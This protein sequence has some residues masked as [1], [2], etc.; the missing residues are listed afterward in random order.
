MLSFKKCKREMFYNILIFNFFLQLRFICTRMRSLK[1][2]SHMNT[3][4]F[5]D[6]IWMVLVLMKWVLHVS[7]CLH[8]SMEHQHMQPSSSSSKCSGIFAVTFMCWWYRGAG[9]KMS[10]RSP[11]QLFWMLRSR[12][13]S[14]WNISRTFMDSS[15]CTEVA[16]LFDSLTV[17]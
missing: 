14:F 13:S 17:T 10:A 8:N 4:H 16:A 5:Q 2:F 11:E 6:R 7:E 1:L 9:W 3:G 12:V 15:T